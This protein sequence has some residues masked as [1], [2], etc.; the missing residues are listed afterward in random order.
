VSGGRA[1]RAA[2]R[3]ARRAGSAARTVVAATPAVCALVVAACVGSRAL[4]FASAAFP[5]RLDDALGDLMSLHFLVALNQGAT[6]VLLAQAAIVGVAVALLARVVA[7]LRGRPR[8]R[9]LPLGPWL[10]AWLWVGLVCGNAVLDLEPGLLGLLVATAP[11]LAWAAVAG[12]RRPAVAAV[13]LVAGFAAW[14]RAGTGPERFDVVYGGAWLAVCAAAVAL[15]PWV[16]RRRDWA[17][18]V[19]LAFGA[20]QA[21]TLA[22]DRL[23]LFR[24]DADALD[25]A[26][27]NVF[28]WCEIPARHLLFATHTTC[29][30]WTL[31]RCRDDFIAVHDLR[32]P[33]RTT[34][35]RFFD[36]RFYGRMMHLLCL[37]DRVQVGMAA[38]LLDGRVRRGN[39]MEFA[40]DDP[41]R[42]V[43]D[44]LGAAS[45]DGV[46]A[47]FL[48]DRAHGV[49]F[50]ASESES[51]LLRV[52]LATGARRR[53]E[54]PSIRTWPPPHRLGPFLL[55]L[56]GPTSTGPDAVYAARDTGFFV[57]WMRGSKVVELDLARDV[58]VGTYVTNNGG[59]QSVAV[60]E[61]RRRLLVTGVW[62]LEAFD[63]ESGRR[64]AR[65]RTPFGPRMP[66]VDAAHDLVF[67][68]TTFGSHLLVLDRDT[69]APLGRLGVGTGGG[70]AQLTSDGTRLFASGGGHTWAW[71]TERLAR[72]FGHLRSS[73]ARS[74]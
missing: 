69:L 67:V 64:T 11:A 10:L 18:A 48:H 32:D 61:G 71:D 60:D 22:W 44:V 72:R 55:S 27:G 59:N 2:A 9:L 8:P 30:V 29:D 31:S 35:L 47:I 6:F 24:P 57:E 68:P 14:L 23:P 63:L 39:V 1:L 3:G 16:A 4:H 53:V 34:Q 12:G 28:H 45:D 70:F 56:P 42:V 43:R 13:A 5:P 7:R 66:V 41:K 52:D 21:S 17:T 20:L 58:E 33:R 40:V 38:T 19:V 46:G 74:P 26:P 65:L 15:R 54:L 36:D 49:V 62:G 50:W 73:H 37:P 51:H 25:V